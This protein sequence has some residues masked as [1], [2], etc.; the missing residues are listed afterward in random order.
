MNLDISS[1]RISAREDVDLTA[2]PTRVA[3]L[4]A[5]KKEYNALLKGNVKRLSR[6]QERFYAAN[7]HALL[8]IFQAMDTAGKDGA[9]EHVM[10][11]V[12]PQGCHVYSFRHP[13]A[14]EL[15]HDFLWRT[16]QCL[17]ERG[18]I[19]VFNRSYYEEVLVVRVHAD[20][21]EAEHVPDHALDG[22]SVWQQ[23]FDSINE[24]ERHLYR[25]G[26]RIVKF[27]LHISK[28][29]QR[30]RL[31]DRIDDP[32]KR[33]KFNLDDVNERAYWDDYM[34]AYER[35]LHAT[36]SKHA[37]WCVIPADDKRNA[38]LMVSQVLLHTLE[39]LQPEF[40]ATSNERQIELEQARE[41]LAEQ[42]GERPTG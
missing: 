24:H 29:E 30:R 18:M 10:S 33:W 7:A 11:G 14:T 27:F 5:S 25:N 20:I 17:P 38:R 21:L 28:D 26:T 13:S 23:R 22:A 37:P 32:D 34:H 41:L 2:R 9:I 16:T 39:E 4:Y 19:G 42:D 8:V 6:L 12:N 3:P 40:P 35:C 15:E 36:S 1:I 31:L